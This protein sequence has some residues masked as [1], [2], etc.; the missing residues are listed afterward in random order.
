MKEF[1]ADPSLGLMGLM[2]FFVF[3]C[4]MLAWVFRPGS[5]KHYVDQGNIPLQE[6][7]E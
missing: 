2:V 6:G 5:K 3:F 4:A 7:K 1:F